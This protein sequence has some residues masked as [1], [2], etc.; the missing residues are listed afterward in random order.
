MFAL[1]I[2]DRRAEG[3]ESAVLGQSVAL[4][5]LGDMKVR[6]PSA[7]EESETLRTRE[8]IF[9]ISYFLRFCNETLFLSPSM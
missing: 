2:V 9:L 7:C 6:W 5:I 8:S 4:M 3:T 1:G